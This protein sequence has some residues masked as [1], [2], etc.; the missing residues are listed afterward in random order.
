MSKGCS[1]TERRQEDCPPDLAT[2]RSLATCR[3]VPKGWQRK[4]QVGVVQERRRRQRRL[5]SR[6]LSRERANQ[7][8]KRIIL[9]FSFFM[10]GRTTAY[11]HNDS[12]RMG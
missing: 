4:S 2:R 5:S 12:V 11:L 3:R 7:S 9:L 10:L 6:S 1:L 8:Q